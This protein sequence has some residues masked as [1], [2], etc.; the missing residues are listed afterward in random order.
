MM[1]RSYH[2]IRD[3]LGTPQWVDDQGVPRYCPFHPSSLGV[4]DHWAAL[5][6]IGC[7]SC[8]HPLLVACSYSPLD[9]VFGKNGRIAATP[10]D[11]ST[12]LLPTPE[13]PGSFG[14]G[15]APYHG[16]DGCTGQSMT[17]EVRRVVQ[18]WIRDGSW[19]GWQRHPEFEFSYSPKEEDT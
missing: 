4:Y 12:P 9:L 19:M 18:F 7:Q 5:L 11:P 15:D 13:N 16:E 8:G 14:F 1:L 2:D 17:T 6:E 3:R 10:K